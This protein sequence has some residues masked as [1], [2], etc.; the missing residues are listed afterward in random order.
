MLMLPSSRER[1]LSVACRLRPATDV[2]IA[3]S[4]KQVKTKLEWGAPPD[5]GT[6]TAAQ[7]L[8]EAELQLSG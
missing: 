4:A 2:G 1:I 3:H 5:F 8:R 6:R 7:N